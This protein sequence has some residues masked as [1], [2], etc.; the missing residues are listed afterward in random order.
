MKPAYSKTLDALDAALAAEGMT[1]A[2]LDPSAITSSEYARAKGISRETAGRRLAL[3]VKSG[4]FETCRKMIVQSTGRPYP[5][6]AYRP[7]ITKR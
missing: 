4:R 6:T 3:L 2:I 5:A 1:E 7:K